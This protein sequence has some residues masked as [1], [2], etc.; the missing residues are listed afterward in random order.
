MESDL[1]KLISILL[2]ESEHAEEEQR[3]NSVLKELSYRQIYC[4]HLIEELRNP[5]ISELAEKLGI[6]KASTS[7]L[8]DRLCDKGFVARVKSDS[9]RR[10][11]HLHL[12]ESGMQ[13]NTVHENVHQ[14]FARKLTKQLTPSE[15]DILKVLLNKALGIS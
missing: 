8:I 15:S 5:T 10:S 3:L 4:L 7:V 2:K 9:D 12:T 13:A 11:A 1:H 6:T 14:K